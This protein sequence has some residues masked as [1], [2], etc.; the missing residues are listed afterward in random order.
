MTERNA[1]IIQSEI[2]Y[3][4]RLCTLHAR[5]YR[6]VRAVLSFCSLAGGSAAMA[7]ILSAQHDWAIAAGVTL[8]LIPILDNVINPGDKSAAH[9]Q[10]RRRYVEL[11]QQLMRRQIDAAAADTQLHG[12][13]A[14]QPDEI[15]GL[16]KAA[17]ND[18]DL[19][20]GLDPAN[21]LSIWERVCHIFA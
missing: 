6:R 2:D 1:D 9:E 10:L 20:R 18:A 8:A 3:N 11:R 21:K 5:C 13:Y 17:Q 15:E 19:Q 14:E 12:L 16:R 7:G 4:I